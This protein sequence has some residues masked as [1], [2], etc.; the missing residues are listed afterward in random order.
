MRGPG[1][2]GVV[3]IRVTDDDGAARLKLGQWYPCNLV[4]AVLVLAS[5]RRGIPAQIEIS[6]TERQIGIVEAAGVVEQ[7]RREIP[8]GPPQSAVR[9]DICGACDRKPI[10]GQRVSLQ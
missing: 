7:T 6:V 1:H 3:G 2:R 10:A 9:G 5:P 8:V 4:A